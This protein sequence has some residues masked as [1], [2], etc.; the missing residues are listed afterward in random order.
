M[1]MRILVV[2]D[3][4]TIRDSLKDILESEGFDV[5]L[6]GD[7]IQA[8]QI[9]GD[10]EFDLVLS[11]IKMPRMDGIEL[12]SHC[13]RH[14]AH[15]PIIMISAH[16]NVQTAVEATKLGAFDFITKPLDLDRLLITIR[17]ALQIRALK[18]EAITW[19][20]DDLDPVE[21]QGQSPALLS[22]KET[23]Q[24]VAPTDVRILISGQAG[25]G[26]EWI[27]RFIHRLSPRNHGPFVSLNCAT[28]PA[29]NLELKLFGQSDPSGDTLLP[30]G[31]YNQA[32]GGTLFL[33]EIA[34]LPG[35]AQLT[36]VRLL[37]SSKNQGASSRHGVRILA[38]SQKDL[39]QLI[40]EGK[41][42]LDLYHLL[43]VIL[44]HL[45]SLH[46][47]RE[48]IPM[49]AGI[50]LNRICKQYQLPSLHF[51]SEALRALQALPWTG[52]LRELKNAVERLAILAGP[53]ITR[54]DVQQYIQPILSEGYQEN[55][56]AH[57]K[58]TEHQSLIST[59]E[60]DNFQRFKEL[61]EKIFVELKLK[62]NQWNIA[63]TA[64]SIGIQRS[65]LYNKIERYQ[66]SK[67]KTKI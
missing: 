6:A 45:P 3:E 31:Y 49:L 19:T 50:Y 61:T 53:N 29:D 56:M 39:V 51:E 15:L 35:P 58:Q 11:D 4:A 18:Q 30:K 38:G 67:P 5:E 24:R 16:G 9:L 7:G 27:A 28:V 20:Q 33:D 8:L 32:L 22:L 26:K 12:L 46:Q 2:D 59:L 66:L 44:V 63:K 47:R 1:F 36:L 13:A 64:E 57:H 54:K 43:S 14:Y 55:S 65:H 10:H 52:N 23:L 34:D 60:E 25:T 42:R 40:D 21:L 17:N 62:E 41:F 37:E 48:D